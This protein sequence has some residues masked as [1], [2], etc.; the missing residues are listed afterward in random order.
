MQSVQSALIQQQ[1]IREKTGASM[2][3]ERAGTA[4]A[5]G[6]WKLRCACNPRHPGWVDAG[7]VFHGI[8]SSVGA[9]E[10]DLD[11]LIDYR[12]KSLSKRAER[13]MRWRD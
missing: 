6:A 11:N 2:D 10:G 12:R 8:E 13:G 1:G 9:W 7:C 5:G 4:S 3:R